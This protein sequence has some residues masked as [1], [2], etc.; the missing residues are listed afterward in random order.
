LS[1]TLAAPYQL[2]VAREDVAEP[3][4]SIN[5]VF[6]DCG[7]RTVLLTHTKTGSDTVEDV[8]EQ[9]RDE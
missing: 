4:F 3:S 1:S 6:I 8:A 9:I 7:K 2:G 5:R